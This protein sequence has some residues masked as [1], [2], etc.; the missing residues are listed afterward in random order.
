MSFRHHAAAP[1]RLVFSIVAGATLGACTDSPSAS[2]NDDPIAFAV[3]FSG[4][5]SPPKEEFG[6]PARFDLAIRAHGSFKPGHPIQLTLEAITRQATRD[7][8]LRVTLPEI[9][10]AEVSGWDTVKIPLNQELRPHIRIRRGFAAGESVRER[11]SIMIPEPGYYHAVATAYAHPDPATPDPLASGDVSRRDFWIL[12]DEQGGRITE[13]FD[14]T[15]IATGQRKE[16]GP[17]APEKNPPRVHHGDATI[18]C[19]LLPSDPLFPAS[20]PTATLTPDATT[21]EGCPDPYDPNAPPPSNAMARIKATYVDAGAGST[22]RPVA[23][24][25]VVWRLLTVTGTQISQGEGTL[26]ADGTSPAIDCGAPAGERRISAFLYT[27]SQRVNVSFG[28]GT[29]ATNAGTYSTTCGGEVVVRADPEMAHL[30]VNLQKNVEG[31]H[32]RFGA[33][34]PNRIYAGLYIDGRT[35]YHHDHPDHELHISRDPRMIYGEY[36]I[37]VAAHEY[38]HQFQHRYLFSPPDSDGLMRYQNNC[39][40]QH[41]PEAPS[42][43]GCALGEGFADWYA[44]HVREA[45]MPTWKQQLEA[46]YYYRNCVPR[47]D[48]ERGLTI[49]CVDDGSIIQG[50]VAALLWDITDDGT[51]EAD[52]PIQRSARDLTDAIK[53]CR[54]NVGTAS[55]GYTGIDHVIF[56]FENAAPYTV[57]LSTGT[58]S[59]FNTR[60]TLPTSAM[61]AYAF[62]RGSTGFRRNWLINL[63]S[64]RSS[65][66]PSPTPK[67]IVEPEPEPG[68]DPTCP[69]C[70]EPV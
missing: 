29:E 58:V 64:K 9:T 4:E 63:Y 47:V 68:P 28:I 12:V 17:R 34:P 33:Y 48:A 14:P 69:S 6:G 11:V 45:D 10:S 61:S 13:G 67:L 60:S 37:M 27:V 8:E 54:V 42:N 66:G 55:L 5:G 65:V 53:A 24:A 25:R 31:H 18:A 19:S 36:G 15:L 30:F 56:C 41:P 44:T 2:V 70:Q 32:T 26:A 7:G 59:L 52:D 22:V 21:L 16:P 57:Q 35:Y 20:N 62:F 40:T 38:G 51:S 39:R 49:S 46:N 50:A 43:L 3:G 23:G 1:T